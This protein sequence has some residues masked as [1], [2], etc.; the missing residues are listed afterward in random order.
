ML[1]EDKSNPT[2]NNIQLYIK[3][4][5]TPNYLAISIATKKINREEGKPN[6]KQDPQFRPRNPQ[7]AIFWMTH[8][9]LFNT[10]C[11]LALFTSPIFKFFK[12]ISSSDLLWFSL[13][14]QEATLAGL[15]GRPSKKK[16]KQNSDYP[17]REHKQGCR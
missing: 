11:P 3:K 1:E 14:K 6:Q 13:P 2:Q 9:R 16:S 12:P 8:K 5:K 17:F 15:G 7:R 4:K 10:F